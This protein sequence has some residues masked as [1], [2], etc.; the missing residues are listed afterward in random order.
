MGKIIA[1]LHRPAMLLRGLQ[2]PTTLLLLAIGG[3]QLVLHAIGR[4]YAAMAALNDL[5]CMLHGILMSAPC[6]LLLIRHA[7][8]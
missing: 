2:S 3:S 7:C 6:E 5:T 1:G 4:R 8:S